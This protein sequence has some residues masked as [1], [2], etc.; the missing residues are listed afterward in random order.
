MVVVAGASGLQVAAAV[1]AD[2]HLPAAAAIAGKLSNFYSFPESPVQSVELRTGLVFLSLVEFNIMY[3]IGSH[4][5]LASFPTS[6]YS[7][8]LARIG[9]RLYNW[10]SISAAIFRISRWYIT[11]FIS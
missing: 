7:T 10:V 2:V 11:G 9:C 4:E 8:A 3:V 1:E 6:S 5:R